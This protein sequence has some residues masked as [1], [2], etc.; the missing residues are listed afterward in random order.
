MKRV[1]LK[2]GPRGAAVV[3]RQILFTR[4]PGDAGGHNGRRLATGCCI[5]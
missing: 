3:G 2:L 1:A 4:R 5:R